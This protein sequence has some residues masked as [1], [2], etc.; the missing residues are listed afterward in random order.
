LDWIKKLKP[1]W[2]TIG[3]VLGLWL[4]LR[5]AKRTESK[6]N[7][8]KANVSGAARNQLLKE[9]ARIER[10]NLSP[11]QEVI[12]KF[13]A[14]LEAMESTET[15]WPEHQPPEI[16]AKRLGWSHTRAQNSLTAVSHAH[17]DCYYGQIPVDSVRLQRFRVDFC[18]VVDTVLGSSQKASMGQRLE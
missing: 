2:V 12:R 1:L 10:A 4:L 11:D 7:N 3:V 13:C 15:P 16:Y 14:F 18:N 17:S 5:L 8:R 6:Q 9:I